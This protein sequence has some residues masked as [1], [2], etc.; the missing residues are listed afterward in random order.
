MYPNRLLAILALPLLL[1][2]ATGFAEPA[3]QHTAGHYER[4][5][6]HGASLVGNLD[7][8]PAD[9]DVS[10]YLPPGYEKQPKRR[11]PV[12]YLLHGFTDSDSCWFGL[13]KA[14]FVH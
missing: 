10:I 7:G 6:V 1:V 14:H 2:P 13:E 12:L 9:R 8:D 4:V 5:K 11:Y 3:S